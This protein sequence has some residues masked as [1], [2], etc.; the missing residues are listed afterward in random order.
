[1]IMLKVLAGV[2]MGAV[3]G[4]AAKSLVAGEDEQ[5]MRAYQ[6]MATIA[7]VSAIAF[8]IYTGFAYSAVFAFAAIGELVVG[9]LIIG[10]LPIGARLVLTNAAPV[11]LV[12]AWIMA[13][14]R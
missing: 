12:A 10:F 4:S 11:F 9:A 3:A 2:L 1:M 13:V 5:Q 8:V 6:P 14:A 7:A